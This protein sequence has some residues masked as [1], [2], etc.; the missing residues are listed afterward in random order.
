MEGEG[1]YNEEKGEYYIGHFSNNVKN[2]KGRE[3]YSNRKLKYEGDY[4]NG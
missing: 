4:I 1:R 3:Y 2:G